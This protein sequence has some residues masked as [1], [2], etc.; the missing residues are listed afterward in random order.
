MIASSKLRR[1]CK[2]I[3]AAAPRR[4]PL[5][6]GL[7]GLIS[8]VMY[9]YV[10]YKALYIL[11][12]AAYIHLHTGSSRY[13]FAASQPQSSAPEADRW[14]EPPPRA[15]S[16]SV[17]PSRWILRLPRFGAG[18]VR[19]AATSARRRSRED[20]GR[21]S[22][23]CIAAD[24]LSSGSGLC[25]G[26][27]ERTAA[28]VARSEGCTQAHARSHAVYRSAADRRRAA[29][30]SGPSSTDRD[31]TGCLGPPPQYRTRPGAQKKTIVTAAA[32]PPAAVSL[33][34]TLRSDV[35]RGAARPD[36]LGAVI[37]HGMLQGLVLL[38]SGPSAPTPYQP[39]MASAPNVRSDRGLVRLLANMV[40]QTH[41]E[42]KH[43]F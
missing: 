3:N 2:I 40:L 9:A 7:K 38:M 17:V 8:C 24:V 20:R 33:Y 14:P 43:V 34:E 31:R 27:L 22:F 18:Q 21:F 37:Y 1:V 42:V 12:C 6:F 5:Q 39:H 29:R 32:L 25:A 10:R 19:D 4:C 13:A 41:L 11:T 36:G 28:E 26:R 16:C 15:C 23:R 30:G 35:L